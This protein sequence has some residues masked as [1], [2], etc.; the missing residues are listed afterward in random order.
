MLSALIASCKFTLIFE[1]IVLYSDGFV[2]GLVTHLVSICSFLFSN[3]QRV[4]YPIHNYI[5]VNALQ[6]VTGKERG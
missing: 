3:L 6:L 2:D 4:F 5:A 1:K